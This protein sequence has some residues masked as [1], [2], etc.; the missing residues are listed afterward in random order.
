M[1]TT[2]PIDESA[3]GAYARTWEMLVSKYNTAGSW[4]QWAQTVMDTSMDSI[5]DKLSSSDTSV[6]LDG[7][8]DAISTIPS[9][10]VGS[11]PSYSAPSAPSYLSIPSYSAPTLGTILSIPDVV[12]LAI[13]DAPDATI[14]HTE[15]PFSDD[16]LTALRSRIEA[17]MA[18]ATAA[19]AAMFARHSQRAYDEST[20]AYNEIT[21]QFSSRG[22]ELPPGALLAKQ[23]EMANERTKR[24][25]DAS[26]DIMSE[27]A[28]QAFSGALQMIDIM[29]RLNDNSVMRAFEVKK[30]EVQYAI[31]G[32]K[33]VID[34]MKAKG[35]LNKSAIEATVSANKGTIEAFTGQIEGQVA[36]IKALADSNKAMADA[37]KAAV[38]GAS[39]SVQA[40]IAP[41]E[42]K[43]K[44]IGLDVQAA[45]A[46]GEIASKAA[47]LD[48]E[49]AKNN[50]ALQ[51][52]ALQGLAQSAAQMIASA[53]NSVHA[54]T[55][56]GYSAA[57]TSTTSTST[58][59]SESTNHNLNY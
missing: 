12:D 49:N 26:A 24:L 50:L 2:D 1:P 38:D 3:V 4:A 5:N 13:P 44:G 11:I 33:A 54:S 20:K 22:F 40:A 21:T 47:A 52:S 7:I 32:F 55:S 35:D 59:T 48:I 8:L 17:D 23:T 46:K 43:I 25:T 41:E 36:P 29:G 14:V 28:K 9:Y 19:E 58:S 16:V 37:Y 56:F 39:A 57:S 45:A 6:A 42:L 51:V 10:S 18:G 15:T 27:A 53:L 30:A 34:G 31:E